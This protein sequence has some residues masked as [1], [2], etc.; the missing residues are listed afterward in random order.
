MQFLSAEGE[1]S[2]EE[3]TQNVR[4]MYKTHLGIKC[5]YMSR[6]YRSVLPLDV[7]TAGVDSC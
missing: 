3:I 4:Q 2:L 7:F 6:S 5:K 1:K